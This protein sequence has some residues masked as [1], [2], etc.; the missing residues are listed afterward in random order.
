MAQATNRAFKRALDTVPVQVLRSL[1]AVPFVDPTTG[2]S[3]A[4]GVIRECTPA[5]ARALL[6]RLH[7]L[8]RNLDPLHVAKIAKA[9]TTGNF[10][11]TGDSIQFDYEGRLVNGQ[12]R[13]TAHANAGVTQDLWVTVVPNGSFKA[14]D[15]TAKQRTLMQLTK[16]YGRQVRTSVSAAII[17]ETQHFPNSVPKDL[18][19]PDRLEIVMAS[20]FL[21][22]VEHLFVLSRRRA[23]S[24]ILAG[25]IACMRANKEDA[26]RFFSAAAANEHRIDGVFSPAAKALADFIFNQTRDKLKKGTTTPLAQREE[27]AKVINAWNRYRKG[28]TKSGVLRGTVSRDDTVHGPM[29]IPVG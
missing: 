8:Q 13:C 19:L 14:I 3:Q 18:S 6:D 2:E 20:E 10:C 27:A 29:P 15:T 26:F 9:H 23:N 17:V 16:M 1:G 11:F 24:G 12:H 22:Q 5:M 25:M 7:P 28:D 4:I 21:P